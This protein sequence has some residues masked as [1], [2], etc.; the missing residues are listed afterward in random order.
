M[1]LSG[2]A[3]FGRLGLVS[4]GKVVQ[5]SLRYGWRGGA[6]QGTEGAE[7]TVW[8]GRHGEASIGQFWHGGYGMAGKARPGPAGFGEVGHE[9]GLAGK[10]RIGGNGG[11]RRG[12]V[13]QAKD[14]FF[15]RGLGMVDEDGFDRFWNEYP[16][17]RSKGDAYKAWRSVNERRPTTDRIVKAVQVLKASEDWRRDGGQYIPY[18]GTWLRAWGWEDVPT[19]QLQDVMA[20]GK[21]WWE[22]VSGVDQK[23]AQLGIREE[24]YQSRAHFRQAVFK[25]AGHNVGNVMPVDFIDKKLASAGN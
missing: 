21:M 14:H 19:V 12:R 1:A 10:V 23:A 9:R 15:S 8:L 17:K 7:G 13:W 22:S 3:S 18:P 5:G 20:N 16:K 24:N 2:K 11:S 4:P 25:A 6:R